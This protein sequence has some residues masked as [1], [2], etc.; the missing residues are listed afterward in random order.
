MAKKGVRATQFMYSAAYRPA[1]AR[2]SLGKVFTRFQM[3][4]YKSQALR[5]EVM[6]NVE[7][8]GFDPHSEEGRV[9]QR[10]VIGDMIMLALANAF[11]FSLFENNLP[12]PYGWFQDT[13]EWIFGDE[14][15]RD[16]AFFG[17]YPTAVA[18]LQVITPPALRLVGPTIKALL[19]DDWNRIAQYYIYTMFPFGVTGKDFMPWVDNNLIEAPQR[20]IDK[21]I[22]VPMFQLQRG[23]KKLKEQNQEDTINRELTYPRGIVGGY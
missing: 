5:G 3:Y 1:F 22:G 21:W 16:K 19:D 11:T 17:A 18:P 20:I 2:T 23:A 7:I 14:K 15:E 13:A 6:R 9:A 4:A 10:F 8:A 12:Q